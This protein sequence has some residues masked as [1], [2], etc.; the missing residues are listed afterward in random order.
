MICATGQ[1]FARPGSLLSLFRVQTSCLCWLVDGISLRMMPERSALYCEGLGYHL[2]MRHLE[3][4]SKLGLPVLA[5]NSS[6]YGHSS[7]LTA[8]KS[9]IRVDQYGPSALA[10]GSLRSPHI[11]LPEV[12]HGYERHKWALIGRLPFLEAFGCSSMPC[13]P[14]L[15][16]VIST[17]MHW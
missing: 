15:L 5:S 3:R 1:R 6:I 8:P 7:Q 17:D 9:V 12:R 2:Q 11:L 16:T 10:L 14:V 13:I 4:S